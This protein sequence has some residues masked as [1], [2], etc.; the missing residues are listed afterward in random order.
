MKDRTFLVSVPADSRYLRAIRSF[1]LP[2]LEETL[3][4]SAAQMVILALDE[5]CSN[6]IKHTDASA[7][8]ARRIHVQASLGVGGAKF[9][10][11]DFCEESDVPNIKPRDLNQLRPGG[12]GTHFIN[13]IMD[14]IVFEPDP[15]TPGRVALVMEKGMPAAEEGNRDEA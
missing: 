5:A 6:I 11:R 2:V 8:V 10:L 7:L 14:R 1:Y 13:K 9:R 3:G 4:D 12:L 15:E